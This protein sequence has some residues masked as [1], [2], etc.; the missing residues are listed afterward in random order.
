MI[1]LKFKME[2]KGRDQSITGGRTGTEKRTS[3]E[4]VRLPRARVLAEKTE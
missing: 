2:R 3:G 1:E 4:G